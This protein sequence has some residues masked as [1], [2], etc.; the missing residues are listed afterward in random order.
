MP[1]DPNISLSFRQP[2]QP[3]M[4]AQMGQVMQLRQLQQENEQ[5]N[6]LNAAYQSAY[7]GGQYDPTAVER[8]LA[9]GSAAHMIPK[10][11][12]QQ[13]ALEKAQAEVKK[14]GYDNSQSAFAQSRQAL[15]QIDPASPNAGAQLIAWHQANHTDP[16]MGPILKA[17]GINQD[18]SRA[19]IEAAIAKGPA[20]IQ[21]AIQRYALGQE[22][23]Q[24]EVMQ[25]E[26]AV[27]T[28]NISAA[29]GHRQASL[30]EQKYKDQ[31]TGGGDIV[32]TTV[33]NP[34][35]GEPMEIQARRDIPTGQL[36]PLEVARMPM[37]VQ[38]SPDSATSSY[39][40]SGGVANN[41]APQG[42]AAPATSVNELRP[43]A[44]TFAQP[45]AKVPEGYRKTANGLEFIPGGPKDPAVQSQQAE[46]KLSAKDL[47]NREAKYPQ[48]TTAL[49]GFEAKTAKFERDIDELLTNKKGLDEITGYIAG[50]TNLSAMSKEGQRALALY[51][52][53]TAKGGFSELQDMRNS[54][55]T[56]GA[57]GNV[58][59][60]EGQQLI[61]SFGALSRTQSGDDLR[62]TLTTV[63][64]DLQGSK[65]RVRDAYDM[66]YDYKGSG[67]SGQANA[68]KEDPL[69]IR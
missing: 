14:I 19:D 30:A 39:Q 66:T 53:I 31:L 42:G 13:A 60:Q 27:K 38:I 36:I 55:P 26:R 20:A 41:L 2:E 7:A 12:Q 1:I 52:T 17:S 25:T 29:P 23:F 40:T 61:N 10:V 45:F 63:K 46:V 54:S 65:Q 37:R 16:V 49:N 24:K 21:T 3:N 9:S 35:T 67:A 32:V 58:S 34:E 48:A 47:A 11:R 18:S 69:G 43:Q 6:A 59:N 50:R 56:G 57:L 15:T 8:N 33:P 22:G 4:L 5:T 62:K 44:T 28:A 51:N 64:S 68:P